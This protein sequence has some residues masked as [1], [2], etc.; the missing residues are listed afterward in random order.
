VRDWTGEVKF[1]LSVVGSRTT[2]E[3]KPSSASVKAL[4]ESSQRA[5]IALGGAAS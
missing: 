1:A 4:L 3:V 5:T 2:L